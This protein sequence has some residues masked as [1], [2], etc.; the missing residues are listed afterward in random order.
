MDKKKT[1][2]GTHD[3]GAETADLQYQRAANFTTAYAN[4]VYFESS[5]WDLKIVFG[6]LEQ[7]PGQPVV[8]TQHTA[9][10]IPWAQAKLALYYLRI[11]VEGSE[12][13]NGKISIRSNLLPAEPPPLTPEQEKD[14]LAKQLYELV[15]K[16][17]AEFLESF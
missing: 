6:Q 5:A 1:A 2:V 17:R 14:P 16:R 8:V 12:L 9:V 10:T 11:H 15:R 4:N 3:S 13:Q 7:P